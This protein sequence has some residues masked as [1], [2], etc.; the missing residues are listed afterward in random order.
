M[1][2]TRCAAGVDVPRKTPEFC[3]TDDVFS[4]GGEVVNGEM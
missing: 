1:T 3:T 2:P 4:G